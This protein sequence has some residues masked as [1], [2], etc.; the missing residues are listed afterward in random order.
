MVAVVALAPELAFRTRLELPKAP[1]DLD[2]IFHLAYQCVIPSPQ[3]HYILYSETIREEIKT[4]VAF[5]ENFSL[6]ESD[7]K[8][9]HTN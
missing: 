2:E 6:P 7:L 4:T 1:L 8:T 9:M 3:R 5:Y